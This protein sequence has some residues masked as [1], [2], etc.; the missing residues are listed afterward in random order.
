MASRFENMDPAR[1]DDARARAEAFEAA[2]FEL[3]SQAR[4]LRTKGRILRDRW[5][6]EMPA[7]VTDSTEQTVDS[8]GENA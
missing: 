3:E 8:A 5:G 6:I 7:S 1:V 4:V 2:A